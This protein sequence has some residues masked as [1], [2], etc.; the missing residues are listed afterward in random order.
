MT[1]AA[2]TDESD[3]ERHG[4]VPTAVEPP[5]TPVNDATLFELLLSLR[6]RW[7]IVLAMAMVGGIAGWFA[8]Q[9]IPPRYEAVGMVRMAQVALLVGVEVQLKPVEMPAQAAER[10]VMPGFLQA[11]GLLQPG[12]PMHDLKRKVSA[13]PVRDSD[14]LE[15]SYRDRSPE[16]A[17]QGLRK[18]FDLLR[19]RQDA[20]AQPARE[21]IAQQLRTV[22]EFR[23]AGVA[24]GV[25][26][27][28][29]ETSL[30]LS[31][32]GRENEL[33]RWEASLQAAMAPPSTA[34]ATLIE[35]VGINE[36]PVG[37]GPVLLVLAGVVAGLL[38]GLAVA[39][40]HYVA[41]R[42]R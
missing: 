15:I 36:E 23:R 37:P 41:L 39:L 42:R 33:L 38:L 16:S 21:T 6:H 35:G 25:R 11:S 24:E 31:F 20:L 1:G 26:S 32:A 4:R 40:V 22:Q 9:S 8:S 19:Q 14:L 27:A 7:L 10:V 12:E 18:I 30:Q 3:A 34:P 17:G 2:K 13:R 29:L 5:V 28:R